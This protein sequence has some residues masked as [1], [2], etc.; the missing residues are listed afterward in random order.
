MQLIRSVT[1][2]ALV[3][4]VASAAATPPTAQS[5]VR[6]SGTYS[7]LAF[8][9]EGGDLLGMEI[10]I[11]PASNDRFQAAILVSEGAPAPMVLVDLHVSGRAISFTVPARNREIDDQW[12]FKGTISAKA[13]KGTITH[14]SGAKEQ[15]T[16]P[17]RCGYWD[18]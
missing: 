15:V 12:S 9:E 16:L 17:R 11:V 7:N 3:C 14:G 13:L 4:A 6:V 2:V 1:L 5:A 8:N 18:R 10:K